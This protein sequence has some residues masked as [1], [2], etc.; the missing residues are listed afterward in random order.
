[1]SFG[2]SVGDLVAVSSLVFRV[3]DVLRQFDREGSTNSPEYYDLKEQVTE[4]NSIYR[5]IERRGLGNLEEE[6]DV[7]IRTSKD[8]QVILTELEKFLWQRADPD[9]FKPQLS[10]WTSLLLSRLLLWSPR[11]MKTIE[12]PMVQV[13]TARLKPVVSELQPLFLGVTP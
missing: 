9:G 8:I 7:I 1:M 12:K 4:L 13:F 10:P 3:H 6:S 2:F 5:A 11:T